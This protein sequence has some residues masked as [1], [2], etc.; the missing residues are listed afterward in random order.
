MSGRYD[1]EG[2]AA[3]ART[4]DRAIEDVDTRLWRGTDE[5]D[6][7]KYTRVKQCIPPPG[8]GPGI[9]APGVDDELRV[10]TAYLLRVS[11]VEGVPVHAH[12]PH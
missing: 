6:D 7:E 2:G 1:G 11:C 3:H 4:I 8:A 10:S 9:V 5:K 12:A